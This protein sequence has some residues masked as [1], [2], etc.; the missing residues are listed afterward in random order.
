[1][2][3]LLTSIKVRLSTKKRLRNIEC[4]I[5]KQHPEL[6][7]IRMGYDFLI[8]ELLDYIEKEEIKYGNKR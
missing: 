8:K 1:M 6:K 2:V 4:I 3:D 7:N 5:K